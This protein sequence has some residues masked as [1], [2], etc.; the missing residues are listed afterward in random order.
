MTTET[1]M[2]T[3]NHST[4]F[5]ND[6]LEAI[7]IDLAHD[8]MQLVAHKEDFYKKVAL[9][10]GEIDA[11]DL[12]AE[13]GFKS[14]AEYAMNVLGFKQAF[15]YDMIKIGKEF[16]TLLTDGTDFSVSQLKEMLRLT[17]AQRATAI[18]STTINPDMTTKEIREAVNVIKPTKARKVNEKEYLWVLMGFDNPPIKATPSEIHEQRFKEFDWYEELKHENEHY[19]VGLYKEMPVMWKR[20]DIPK[21]EKSGK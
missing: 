17:D 13:D 14:C 15:A 10:L 9:S 19:I 4:A 8:S 1:N 6:R 3:L 2:I 12:Y 21:D 11:N 5:K 20:V 16:K 18:N 7:T